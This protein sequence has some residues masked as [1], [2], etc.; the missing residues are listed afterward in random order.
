MYREA[1]HLSRL[2]GGPEASEA[3]GD[4]GDV[5]AEVVG[6]GDGEGGWVDTGDAVVLGR[7][8]APDGGGGGQ[9][10]PAPAAG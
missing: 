5:A 9:R 10:T 8:V 7:W 6:G 4:G 2:D 3:V 1:N